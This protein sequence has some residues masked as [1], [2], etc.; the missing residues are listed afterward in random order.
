[1]LLAQSL[2]GRWFSTLPPHL[3]RLAPHL[4][5]LPHHSRKRSNRNVNAHQC[6]VYAHCMVRITW[7]L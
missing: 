4:P 6:R 7:L 3:R 2:S 5:V 1:M